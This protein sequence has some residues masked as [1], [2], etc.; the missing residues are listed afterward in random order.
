[1]GDNLDGLAFEVDNGDE[2]DNLGLYESFNIA[3]ALSGLTSADDPTLEL[4]ACNV[5]SVALD[6]CGI[7]GLQVH[8]AFCVVLILFQF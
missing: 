1:M 7:H 6:G 8:P 5:L 4:L 3:L 2:G